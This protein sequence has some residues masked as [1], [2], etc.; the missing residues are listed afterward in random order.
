MELINGAL[1]FQKGDEFNI[2]LPSPINKNL[3]VKAVPGKRDNDFCYDCCFFSVC[4][5]YKGISPLGVHCY[6]TIFELSED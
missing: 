1:V 2:R 6:T 3:K 5:Q 4:R